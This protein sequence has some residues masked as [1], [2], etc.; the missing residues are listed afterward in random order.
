MGGKRQKH[1]TQ[2][3]SQETLFLF[4]RQQ[5][6]FFF[7]RMFRGGYIKLSLFVI[8]HRFAN[9]N[10]LNISRNRLPHRLPTKCSQRYYF[11]K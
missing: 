9:I 2:S 3:F 6:F 10:I 4:G 1:V 5:T 7:L 8:I 11:I